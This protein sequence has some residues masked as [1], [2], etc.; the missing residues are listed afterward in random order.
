MVFSFLYF[1]YR[2]TGEMRYE[3][4]L[5]PS[6]SLTISEFDFN[7]FQFVMKDALSSAI[8][9][10]NVEP[11]SDSAEFTASKSF[12]MPLYRQIFAVNYQKEFIEKETDPAVISRLVDEAWF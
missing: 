1:N 12:S 8:A 3:L 6:L 2:Y 5:F 4:G 7:F 11:Y 10:A 9:G